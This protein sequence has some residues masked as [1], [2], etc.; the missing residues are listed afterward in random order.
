MTS[1]QPP[2]LATWMLHR[3]G[4]GRRMES[5]IG[6]LSEQYANGRSVGWYWRQT[7]TAIAT[8]FIN[9]S[10][11]HGPSL[12]LA[13]AAAWSVILIWRELNALLI[14]IS[15][16]IYW[17]LR[18]LFRTSEFLRDISDGWD[19]RTGPLVS[20]WLVA[21]SIRVLSF[22]VSGW[23][24]AR[25]HSANPWTA[26]LILATTVFA[27]RFPWLQLRVIES[28]YALLIHYTT[29]VGGILLGG[30]W[31]ARSRRPECREGKP[32]PG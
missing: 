23:V 2:R 19:E 15:G 16:D 27:W 32:A 5:L 22:A 18:K 17:P 8:G 11:K 29:A 13:L 6:D 24:A 30:A 3:F 28:E 31:V 1:R 20:I 10:R 21:A 14:G 26:L 12:V 9:A 7:F 25:V 4:L